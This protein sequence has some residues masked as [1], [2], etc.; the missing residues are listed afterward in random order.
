MFHEFRG[1]PKSFEDMLK[2]I[3][4]QDSQLRIRRNRAV[5][6]KGQHLIMM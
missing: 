2:K 5:N 3:K 4:T 1:I 6:A